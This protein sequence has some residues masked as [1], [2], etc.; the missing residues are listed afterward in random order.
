MASTIGNAWSISTA[1][2]L[3]DQNT[4]G[5]PS[6]FGTR[7]YVLGIDL[8]DV[9]RFVISVVGVVTRRISVTGIA[10][11]LVQSTGVVTRKV[12]S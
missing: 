10:T 6:S 11:R 12:S 2:A 1:G 3:S 5:T 9:V 4:I 7:G 8:P